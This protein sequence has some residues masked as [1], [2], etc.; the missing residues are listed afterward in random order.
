[1]INSSSL[2]YY[3][4]N[5]PGGLICLNYVCIAESLQR[6]QANTSILFSDVPILLLIFNTVLISEL[7]R[8]LILT[9]YW[10]LN[11]S[12]QCKLVL[13]SYANHH[14]HHNHNQVV[15][16]GMIFNITMFTT[17]SCH[18]TVTDRLLARAP[19]T[20]RLHIGTTRFSGSVGYITS[21]SDFHLSKGKTLLYWF[22]QKH[23]FLFDVFV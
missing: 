22:F 21:T 11:N 14:S 4:F 17:L 9:Q 20:S 2:L 12:T 13:P 3:Y 18:N 5:A 7:G 10:T 6:Q 16:M 1:M 19:G 15:L 8:C 23:N